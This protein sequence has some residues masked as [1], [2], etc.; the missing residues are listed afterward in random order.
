[1]ETKQFC[2][3]KSPEEAQKETE[4]FTKKEMEKLTKI[5][6]EKPH[7]LN[8][9]ESDSSDCESVS[10]SSNRDSKMLTYKLMR[11]EKELDKMEERKHFATLEINNLLLE[12]IDL[13]KE[14]EEIRIQNTVV[15]NLVHTITK[16]HDIKVLDNFD[17]YRLDESN[18]FS[19]VTEVI[20]N[21]Q[22]K[23]LDIND[24][25]SILKTE[26]VNNFKDDKYK[27][28]KIFYDGE[29]SNFESNVKEKYENKRKDFEKYIFQINKKNK[30][31]EILIFSSFVAIVALF[32]SKFI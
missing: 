28:I 7:L 29:I 3:L 23:Y 15:N 4:D 1:M 6:K 9:Y 5:L 8:K 26:L 2:H 16:I 32:I 12:N 31:L 25:I 30:F 14:L 11:K 21:L 20:I 18:N 27:K 13:K 17:D 10:V 19:Y 24:H 22:K